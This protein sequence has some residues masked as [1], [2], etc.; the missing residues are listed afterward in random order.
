MGESPKTRSKYKSRNPVVE[1]K[2]VKKN[3]QHNHFLT[4]KNRRRFQPRFD[5]DR[6]YDDPPSSSSPVKKSIS[7]SRYDVQIKTTLPCVDLASSKH[8]KIRS[9]SHSPYDSLDNLTMERL[10]PIQSEYPRRDHQLHT[11]VENTFLFKLVN[12]LEPK[13]SCSDKSCKSCK[14]S[15]TTTSIVQKN[16]GDSKNPD[17][18]PLNCDMGNRR[19]GKSFNFK[20]YISDLRARH[21]V[22][23]GAGFHHYP[24]RTR[25]LQAF[26]VSILRCPQGRQKSQHQTSTKLS[27]TGGNINA[28]AKSTSTRILIGGAAGTGASSKIFS[29]VEPKIKTMAQNKGRKACWNPKAPRP[30]RIDGTSGKR[31]DIDAGT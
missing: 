14:K 10:P 3:P 31:K 24:P 1:T 5:R 15:N 23:T 29:S 13:L 18:A 12:S 21:S 20:K 2:D 27:N 4:G 26:P 7:P 11:S 30:K 9:A 16:E 6:N 28:S 19:G 22:N 8:R 25:I 17:R